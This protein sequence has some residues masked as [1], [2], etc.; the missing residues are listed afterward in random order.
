LSQRPHWSESIDW[1][2]AMAD[3]GEELWR[4]LSDPKTYVY[5]A[6][7]EQI[8]DQLD[9]VFVQLAGKI[10]RW[11]RRKAELVAGNRWVELLY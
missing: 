4:L 7:L 2:G 11:Q 5:L 10:D 8:R 3:R 6:G 1:Q 9:T